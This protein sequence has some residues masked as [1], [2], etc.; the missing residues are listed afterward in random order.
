MIDHSIQLIKLQLN[1]THSSDKNYWAAAVFNPKWKQFLA[2]VTNGSEQT[3][4]VNFID[5]Q[6]WLQKDF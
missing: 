3:T 6:C 4:A 5:I 1:Y 2:T